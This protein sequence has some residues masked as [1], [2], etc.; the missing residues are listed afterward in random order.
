MQ[1][2]LREAV[3]AQRELAVR[4]ETIAE[5]AIRSAVGEVV[6]LTAAER[7]AFVAAVRPLHDEA[8]ARFPG[9]HAALKS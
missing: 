1:Q 2:A 8:R 5:Q 7:A 9:A 3:L 4:E 6:R